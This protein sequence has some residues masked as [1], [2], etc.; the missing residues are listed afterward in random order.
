MKRA[1]AAITCVALLGAGCGAH[2]P[3]KAVSVARSDLASSTTTVDLLP[4]DLEVW[5]EPGNDH[6][7]AQLR[8]TA[9]AR[10]ANAVIDVLAHDGYR[11]D[12]MIDWNGDTR[13]RSVLTKHELYA[14]VST[15]ARYGR[16]L[17]AGALPAP[18]LPARLDATGADATLYIGGWAYAAAPRPSTADS[19]ARDVALG[20]L[21]V[22]TAALVLVALAAV[23]HHVKKHDGD[24]C[25][26]AGWLLARVAADAI[27]EYEMQ[28]D[29][30]TDVPESTH[31]DWAEEAD[32][33]QDGP[34]SQIYLEMTLVENRTGAAL[35]HA[36]QRFPGDV[37][38]PGDVERAART[39][40]ASL[41]A[42]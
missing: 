40:L 41:P 27:D 22:A 2:W 5:T 10:I 37:V 8:S 34:D 26:S 3:D 36:H 19:Y 11:L 20:L 31:I 18:A 35:W 25:V 9:E 39:L 33:P 16:A 1:I 28:R 15:L 6:N 13:D 21:V 42:R 7:P 17:P 30:S 14:T 32:V 23:A 4:L 24:H 29:R 38:Q 12:A